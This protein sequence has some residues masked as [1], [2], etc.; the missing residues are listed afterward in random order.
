M[1]IARILKGLKW[2]VLVKWATLSCC[3]QVFAEMSEFRKELGKQYVEGEVLVTADLLKELRASLIKT[4]WVKKRDENGKPIKDQF[5][6]VQE[7]DPNIANSMATILNIRAK[8]FGF[9]VKKVE[10]DGFDLAEWL[11]KAKEVSEK[12]QLSGGKVL[13]HED[14]PNSVK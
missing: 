9:D 6:E 11:L 5:E 3:Y 1:N 2:P 12:R 10:H 7:A 14:T 8:Y 13:E 4:K